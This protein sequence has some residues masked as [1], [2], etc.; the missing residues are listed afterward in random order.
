VRLSRESFWIRVS[1]SRYSSPRSTT[2]FDGPAAGAPASAAGAGPA[3]GPR[4]TSSTVMRPLRPVPCTVERSTP[5]SRARRRTDGDAYAGPSSGRWGSGAV[6]SGGGASDGRADIS[7]AIAVRTADGAAASVGAPDSAL[8]ATVATSVPSEAVSPT[9]S[10]TSCTIP[11][12]G[13]GMSIV[14]LSDSSATSGSSSATESPA[15]TK[16]SITGTSVKSPMSGTRTFSTSAMEPPSPCQ[17]R[18]S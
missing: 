9:L 1:G 16:T 12:T 5:S 4:S 8:T 15:C 14:A 6:G 2:G 11:A 7:A 10:S 17:C 3:L 13:D 18:T